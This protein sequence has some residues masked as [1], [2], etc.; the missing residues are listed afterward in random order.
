MSLHCFLPIQKRC[1]YVPAFTSASFLL[2]RPLLTLVK[3]TRNLLS[4][5]IP[6]DSPYKLPRVHLLAR[7]FIRERDA[8]L[9]SP[10]KL[11]D[12]HA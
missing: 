6:S 8:R 12:A 7:A 3:L 4:S 5:I 1:V 11:E 10:F 9:H 2:C